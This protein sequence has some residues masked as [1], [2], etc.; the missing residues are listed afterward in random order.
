MI[1]KFL[2]PLFLITFLWISITKAQ[3]G[4]L[5]NTFGIGGLST[6]DISGSTEADQAEDMVIQ[7]DGKIIVVGT[8]FD[9]GVFG[10]VARFTADGNLD[11]TF[12]SGGIEIISITESQALAL[13]NDGKIVIVGGNFEI[14]RLNANGSLD[15]GFGSSGIAQVGFAG[16][17]A[18]A[19]DVVIQSDGKIVVVGEVVPG[20]FNMVIARLNSNGALDT[21]FGTAGVVTEDFGF[22]AA[23]NAVALQGD[24]KIVVGGRMFAGDQ[25]FAIIRL[26][27]N[28]DF[29]N[30]FSGDGLLDI[31][32][33][34][35]DEINDIAI[36]SDGKIILVG[37]T[38]N[39]GASDYGIARLNTN[40]SLDNTFNGTGIATYS[41]PGSTEDIP[42]SVHLQ[43]DG[44]I[45]VAGST[46]GAGQTI[47]SILRTS[48]TGV[49]DASF[50]G[51]GF[52]GITVGPDIDEV[53]AIAQ[54]GDGK[55]I[56]AG[57]SDQG[58]TNDDLA[59]ARI[60]A[61]PIFTVINT[62][63]SG[64][65]SLSQAI[66][67]ANT[68]AGLDIISFNIP[69]SDAGYNTANGGYWSIRPI[70]ALPAITGTVLIDGYSQ[71]GSTVNSAII[72]TNATLK[73]ELNGSL[74]TVVGVGF[75]F[76]ATSLSSTVRGLCINNFL[77]SGIRLDAS[78]CVISGCFIG[79]DITGLI[80][81]GNGGLGVNIV[82]SS[83]ILIGNT[84]AADVNL[85]SG[86]GND[87]VG[88]SGTSSSGNQIINNLIGTNRAVSGGI[89]NSQ[90]G[91]SIEGS[92]NNTLLNN[93]IAYNVQGGVQIDGTTGTTNG[94]YLNQNSIFCN[95]NI[96]I[97]LSN[98]GN[99]LKPAP[100]INVASSSSSIIGTCTGCANGEI[101]DVFID[102]DGCTPAQGKRY[103]GSTTVTG[104]AWTLLAANFI[105][106]AATGDRVTAII[107][108]GSN[109]TSPFSSSATLAALPPVL[110]APASPTLTFT[111][112]DAP[113]RLSATGLAV[114][115]GSTP[116]MSS[117]T[118]AFITNYTIG[119]DNLNI[120]VSAGW[121]SSVSFN[122]TTGVLTITGNGTPAEYQAELQKIRYSNGSSAP[123]I[124][125]RT[126]AIKVNDGT[127]DS[128][129]QT[130]ILNVVAVN[131]SPVITNG[132]GT[133]STLEEEP[134]IFN[135]QASDGDSPILTW[136]VLQQPA[137]GN[138]TLNSPTGNNIIVTYT[139][140]LNTNGLDTLVVQVTDG[141]DADI[142]EIY[143][144]VIPLNDAPEIDPITTPQPSISF[145][146][147]EVIINLTGINA[148]GGADE[149]NQTIV[150][151]A[152]SSNP[153]LISNP[154]ITYTS[155][156][157]TGTL[158]YRLISEP[159]VNT[160]VTITYKIKDNGGFALG[161][162]DSTILNFVIP[163]VLQSPAPT[164]LVASALSQTSILLNWQNNAGITATGY[165]IQR[166]SSPTAG[167][168]TIATLNNAVPSSYI[169]EGLTN[170]TQYFYRVRTL[171]AT[172][173]TDYSNISAATTANVASAPTQL[174]ATAIN[175]YQIRL[176][177]LDNSNN[178][179]GFKIERASVYSDFFYEELYFTN[180]NVT[181]IIDSLNI[182]PNTQY[183]Y[184]VRATNDIGGN[185]IYSNEAEV[186]T[187]TD[188]NL[189]IPFAP[190]DLEA[191]AVSTSQ[192]D[193]T[194][195]YLIDP[196]VVYSIERS[197]DDVNFNEID[198]I[199]FQ[200][201]IAQKTYY[202]TLGLQA[203]ITYFY[204]VRA[205]TGGGTS[206]YS[207]T[208]QAVAACN[209]V[210]AIIRNDNNS[211]TICAGKTA[212]MTVSAQVFRA[213][214]QWRRNGN[215]IPGAV[216]DTFYASETGNY[217]CD[218]S[219][220]TGGTCQAPAINQIL[221]VVLGTPTSL[222]INLE[223]ED[224]VASVQ[225]AGAYQWFRDYQ[226]IPGANNYFYKPTQSGVYF[227]NISVDNC[228]STSDIFVFD[229]T[230]SVENDISSLVSVAPNPS[231]DNIRLKADFGMMGDYEVYLVDLAGKKYL[232]DKASKNTFLLEK[233]LRIHRFATGMY[234]LEFK[235]G[236]YIGRRKLIKY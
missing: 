132:V 6:L 93:T 30:S 182:I 140:D 8:V 34:N 85:I 106:T 194:W 21:G 152:V 206:I 222:D 20:V 63:N 120:P 186:T 118:I 154:S 73:I 168:T 61:E 171:T 235:I 100:I 221:V 67:N 54:Q 38:D 219:V 216:F 212:S 11:A 108:D 58:A 82:N 178:E 190:I 111:E 18:I 172:G 128:N 181:T 28:G 52:Q 59:L 107:I 41:F 36:Q 189:P 227:V 117:A 37:S 56:L 164:N 91:I 72:G 27:G 5:D 23:A 217:T 62:N 105:G 133:Y 48:N 77:N 83:N 156:N 22:S 193:L 234:F 137:D 35:S 76:N 88:I 60:N 187:P 197:I 71:S 226:A 43:P 232:L 147:G 188:P 14:L 46:T 31:D 149:A 40:G 145:G 163:V 191:T 173:P 141:I 204:R 98:N 179:I 228:S 223:G 87:G 202:D 200:D 169:D 151:T 211:Q 176:E 124:L 24:G 134:V 66:T 109:N 146:S 199:L 94:N 138:V 57:F 150:I 210:I 127:S 218:I 177:W 16:D 64:F 81:R 51:D 69:T 39:L 157:A 155:P 129:T 53:R 86:N 9:V 203:G 50:S 45:L 32:I 162:V 236:R 184:R 74:E 4:N 70:T 103:L 79:T 25:N 102:N 68:N 126:I 160:D 42:Y 10:Y 231:T 115:A 208:A 167:F 159:P 195:E 144:Q 220:G 47:F 75:R 192:I 158:T 44:K 165:E 161:N 1:T 99:N 230:T 29:D 96:G 112:G 136:T 170:D 97:S 33:V 90:F 17:P 26:D 207:D 215:I 148:G 80:D 13:Q 49:L 198:R 121:V 135:L 205:I 116:N 92:S 225:D 3:V 15:T 180:E 12:G 95:Q 78:S 89:P 201:L 65:G 55:I 7:P 131:E 174:T 110:A 209:L 122:A 119:Q 143:F 125:P 229:I 123:S 233:D 114:T 104:A 213:N 84:S 224:L 153:N 214:Y 142:R 185:S 175:S 166:A 19:R 101:I 2:L 130:I 139:P 183:F 113:L 196:T